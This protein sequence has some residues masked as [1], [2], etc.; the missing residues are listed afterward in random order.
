MK[1]NYKVKQS[2]LIGDIKNFP[3]EVVK[4]MI[5]E[6]VKQ[7][8]TA[9]VEVFQLLVT[10]GQD[11]GGFDWDKTEDGYDFWDEVIMCNFDLFF[12]TYPAKTKDYKVYIVSDGK[13]GK[14]IINTLHKLDGVNAYL[15]SG[16]NKDEIYYIDPI[17]KFIEVC[18]AKNEALYNMITTFYT[19]IEVNDVVVELTMQEI[20]D[21]FGIE[22]KNLR[23]KK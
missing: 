18:D 3:C 5:E 4:K 23:I 9:D 7:G 17:T 8:N 16:N 10:A 13:N 1:T 2:D 20:T 12:D 19:K 14:S 22:V 11:E 21:E 15:Y 6:Q